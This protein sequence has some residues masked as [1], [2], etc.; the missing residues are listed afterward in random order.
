MKSYKFKE[1]SDYIY[2]LSEIIADTAKYKGRLARYEKEIDNLFAELPNAK[3]IE[4]ELFESV[5]D[6]TKAIFYYLFNLL[7]DEAKNA[8]SYRRFRK[9]LLR[10][11]KTLKIKIPTLTSEEAQISNNLNKIRNWGLHIPESLLVSKRQFCKAD[12]AFIMTQSQTIPLPDFEYFE[13]EYLSTLKTDVADVIEA[14]NILEKRMHKDYSILIGSDFK[15]SPELMKVK[16]YIIMDVVQ[17]SSDIQMG[18]T[19]NKALKR[20]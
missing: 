5:S 9:T 3:Y 8:I 12:K 6:K 18:R 17:G 16:P 19:H 11:S 15:L 1:L 20:N 7:G 10:D 4:T 2:Y 13:I 14:V